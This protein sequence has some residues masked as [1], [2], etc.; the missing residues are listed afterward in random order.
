MTDAPRPRV[1]SLLPRSLTLTG[2]KKRRGKA[3]F[4]GPK[5]AQRPRGDTKGAIWAKTRPMGLKT[6]LPTELTFALIPINHNALDRDFVLGKV[7]AC[8]ARSFERSL[9]AVA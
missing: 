4:L 1:A 3:L 2:L 6:G 8:L 9:V 7:S 5:T